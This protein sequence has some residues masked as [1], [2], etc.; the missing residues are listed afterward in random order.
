M[1][2]NQN[3]DMQ[4][5]DLGEQF[6]LDGAIKRIIAQDMDT[7]GKTDIVTLDEA[8]EIHVFYGAGASSAPSFTKS[9]L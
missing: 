9:L 8:G 7:D 6:D 1:W 2:N 3:T 4:R 5:I